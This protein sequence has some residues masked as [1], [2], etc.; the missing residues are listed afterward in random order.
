VTDFH[1]L[2]HFGLTA[3]TNRGAAGR[4]P[5]LRV[6]LAT[7]PQRASNQRRVWLRISGHTTLTVL[8][9]EPVLPLQ[10]PF[11]TRVQTAAEPVGV[12]QPGTGY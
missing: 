7:S 4:Q 8:A 12:H 9:V 6:L 5:V 3:A 10:Q 11:T 2:E 1:A